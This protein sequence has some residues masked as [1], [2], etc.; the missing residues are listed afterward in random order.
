[1]V[2]GTD[3]RPPQWGEPGYVP[4]P[5]QPKPPRVKLRRGEKGVLWLLPVL[6]LGGRVLYLA[7]LNDENYVPPCYRQEGLVY[8][9]QLYLHPVWSIIGAV[10]AVG[11]IVAMV[12]MIWRN[13]HR[14]PVAMIVVS[15]LLLASAVGLVFATYPC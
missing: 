2:S 7:G 15:L 11:A 1:M 4:P 9:S 14:P 5:T 12:G 13:R 8:T 10:L 3:E 6:A